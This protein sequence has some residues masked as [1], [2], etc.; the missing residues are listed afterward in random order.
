MIRFAMSQTG[1][2]EVLKYKETI[3]EGKCPFNFH[4]DEDA[5]KVGM[6]Y[7]TKNTKWNERTLTYLFRL[8]FWTYEDPSL[9]ESSTLSGT[10]D[11][12][13]DCGY[14]LYCLNSECLWYRCFGRKEDD[15][16]TGIMRAAIEVLENKAVY[17][18][19]EDDEIDEDCDINYDIEDLIWA[20]LGEPEYNLYK[21]MEQAIKERPEVQNKLKEQKAT[22]KYATAEEM[23]KNTRNWKTATLNTYIELLKKEHKEFEGLSVYNQDDY[24]NKYFRNMPGILYCWNYDRYKQYRDWGHKYFLVKENGG[25][26]VE[27]FRET[28]DAMYYLTKMAADIENT[29]A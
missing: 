19:E 14:S 26:F 15:A 24:Y 6:E 21:A 8:M 2:N 11:W 13:T 4:T 10:V 20:Y 18:C 17:A 5:R 27:T 7:Y 16:A 28:R 1:V 29:A 12:R 23:Y 9:M 3:T 25:D 22:K